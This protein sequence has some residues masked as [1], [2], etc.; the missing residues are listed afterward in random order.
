MISGVAVAV[1]VAD[2]ASTNANARG[3]LATIWFRL[4]GGDSCN[5]IHNHNNI[6]FMCGHT[7]IGTH[8]HCQINCNRNHVYGGAL[9]SGLVGPLVVFLCAPWLCS[10]GL[11]GWGLVGLLVVC[12]WGGLGCVPVVPWAGSLR[13]AL[14]MSG[15]WQCPR[16]PLWLCSCVALVVFIRGPLC[17]CGT[18]GYALVG[19]WLCS[20]GTL[21]ESLNS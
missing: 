6:K 13:L 3:V 20:R 9:G 4:H 8:Q 21:V 2:M 12:L 10:G 14:M 11:L 16:G 1:T 18:F 7:P 17:S 19:L 15:P 5:Y